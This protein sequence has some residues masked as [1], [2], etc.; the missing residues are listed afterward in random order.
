MNNNYYKMTIYTINSRITTKITK[1]RY[2][3][4]KIIT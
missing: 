4:G 2:L 1:Q 3:M